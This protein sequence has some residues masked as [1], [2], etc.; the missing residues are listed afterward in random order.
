M[1]QFSCG[2][3]VPGCLRQFT[4]DDEAGILQ[5]VAEHARLD[6]GLET[7]PPEISQQVSAA[8]VTV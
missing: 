6:H 5:Q 7:V 2:D 3:V 1:K 4:A 8:L